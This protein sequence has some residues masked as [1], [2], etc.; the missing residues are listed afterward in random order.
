GNELRQD[1]SYLAAKTGFS[2][3]HRLPWLQ[4]ET[5]QECAHG[6]QGNAGPGERG[7]GHRSWTTTHRDR[8]AGQESAA[9]RPRESERTDRQHSPRGRGLLRLE[10]EGDL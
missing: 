3:S 2:L 7:S 9:G 6:C 1:L 8:P 5:D 4:A 10:R